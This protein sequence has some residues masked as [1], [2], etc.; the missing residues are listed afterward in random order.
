MKLFQPLKIRNMTLKNRLVLPA[1]QLG[2]GVKGRRARAFYL[3][4]AKGGVGT[5]IMAGTS[6]DL[7]FDDTAW[8]RPGGVDQFVEAMQ[9][10][11]ADIHETGAKIGIQLWHGNQLPAGS[12]FY[13]REAAQVA[14]SAT[15][16]LRE[17]TED[18]IMSIHHRFA[19]AADRAKQAGLD[20]IELHG[21]HGYL[22]CQF[23]S[24][25]DNRRQDKYG[26][27]LNKRMQFGT[28]LVR[29]VRQA[30][31]DNYPVVYRI[32]AIENLP[33]G[34][35]LDESSQFA[36][37]LEKAGVDMIDVSVGRALKLG[38]APTRKSEMGTFVP[39]AEAIR[40]KVNIPVMA[41]GRINTGEIAESVLENNRADLVG[42]GRQLIADPLWPQKVEE[43]REDEIVACES[44][45]R[46]FGPIRNKKWRPGDRICKI[47]DRA[48]RESDQPTLKII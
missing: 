27:S 23:F 36:A 43:S 46:C 48:G 1:L 4:R 28:E 8:G 34:I 41:V 15:D 40:Q 39:L 2:L 25:L 45:N 12:G 22:L 9:S 29:T 33:G 14:P 11:T 32:G 47:N 7:L 42:V 38:S 31:G 18:E 20:F 16:R 30:V 26:C 6:I 3:E 5:I 35:S 19:A 13:N 10:F 44:C 37:E 24:P 21:A 17:M